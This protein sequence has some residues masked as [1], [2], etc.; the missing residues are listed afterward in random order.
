MK[1]LYNVFWRCLIV[2]NYFWGVKFHHSGDDWLLV[3]VAKFDD[4]GLQGGCRLCAL[5]EADF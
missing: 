5:F 3:D 4:L 2:L 1:R